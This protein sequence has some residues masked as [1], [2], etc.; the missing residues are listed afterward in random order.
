MSEGAVD[1]FGGGGS[2]WVDPLA[3]FSSWTEFL[4]QDY[5]GC[6]YDT[7]LRQYVYYDKE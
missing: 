1:R 5:A 7:E 4:W 2:L 3:A 6:Y